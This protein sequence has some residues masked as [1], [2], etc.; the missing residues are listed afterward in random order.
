MKKS[1]NLIVS[2][3]SSCLVVGLISGSA[4]AFTTDSRE[5]S[6]KSI[7]FV[8]GAKQTGIICDLSDP[9]FYKNYYNQVY[10]LSYCDWD[11]T[12]SNK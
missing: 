12:I 11:K 5:Q 1:K 10:D 7:N 6:E 4:F 9:Y 2:V 3:L 8:S